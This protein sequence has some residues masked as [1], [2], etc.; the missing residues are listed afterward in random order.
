MPRAEADLVGWLRQEYG[1]RTG[2]EQGERMRGTRR[3]VIAASIAAVAATAG[4]CAGGTDKAGGERSETGPVLRLVAYGEP[5]PDEFV[6]AVG[7]L[8]GGS[9]RVLATTGWRDG[10]VDYEQATVE[11]VRRVD[12]VLAPFLVDSVALEARILESPLAAEMLA[13]IDDA[14]VVGLGVLPGALRRPIGFRSATSAA[15]DYRDAAV[16]IRPSRIV[17]RTF[18]ALGARTRP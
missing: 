13:G 5:D 16:G 14:G 9:L 7:R 1:H 6:A 11:D 8:S 3:V 18:R 15:D 12:A 4:A 17:E 10:R 2:Q